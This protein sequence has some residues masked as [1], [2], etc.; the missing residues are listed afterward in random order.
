M[1]LFSTILTVR[2]VCSNMAR[3][4]ASLLRLDQFP[5]LI[6][7]TSLELVPRETAILPSG[8]TANEKICPASEK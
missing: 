1:L 6:K 8:A 3:L 4:L 7:T 5:E 2:D